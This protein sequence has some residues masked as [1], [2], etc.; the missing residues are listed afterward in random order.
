MLCEL[1]QIL[2]LRV[3]KTII[4]C[5]AIIQNG[6]HISCVVLYT[7]FQNGGNFSILQFTCKLALVASLK[8]N[9]LLNLGFKNE[10][11]RAN[12]Q[13]NKEY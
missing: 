3:R 12:L 1:V 6:R 11:K 9:T 8:E 7:L 4:S 13:E 10:A 2:Y 5:P